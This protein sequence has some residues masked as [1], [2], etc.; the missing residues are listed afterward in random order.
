MLA[1][2]R[3]R[4]GDHICGD[5]VVLHVQGNAGQR[6]GRWNDVCI[7]KCAREEKI[8]IFLQLFY[9]FFSLFCRMHH[10]VQCD[11]RN[12]P[13]YLGTAE[14]ACGNYRGIDGG[15]GYPAG[16]KMDRKSEYDDRCR[17]WHF[18][19]WRD[20]CFILCCISAISRRAIRQIVTSAFSPRCAA[21]GGLGYTVG[22]AVRYGVARGLF[23][24]E[25]GLGTSGIAAAC[26]EEKISPEEQGLISMTA[27]FW[28]TVVLCAVTGIVVVIYQAKHAIAKSGMASGL[29]VKEAFA[30][31]PLGGTEII[32]VA[33]VAFAVA[34]LIGWSL[35]GK[36]AA[37][38]LGGKQLTRTYQYIYVIMIFAG[39]VMPLGFV[40]E[41]TDFVNLFLLVPSVYTLLCCRKILRKK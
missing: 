38:F 2:R 21:A 39:A 29:L 23:T 25:A 8:G 16:S 30:E 17:R 4:D 40:W 12:V 28:D 33:T 5:D 22:A 3:A 7:E 19:L 35:F 27:T 41:I 11:F 32:G 15:T 6:T 10:T 34:T 13:G 9:L 1:H 18:F 14:M 37:E 24:N 36:V 26:G 31:L 20:V